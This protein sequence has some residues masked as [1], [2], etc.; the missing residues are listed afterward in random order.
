MNQF[1]GLTPR[2]WHV[3]TRNDG[4]LVLTLDRQDASV[5]ALCQAVLMELDALLT[6]AAKDA[7][8]LR[9]GVEVRVPVSALQPND[10]HLVMGV[11]VLIARRQQR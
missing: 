5:N 1:S 2:H 4:I 11:L 8:V 7:A 9:D 3:E 10:R 6:L